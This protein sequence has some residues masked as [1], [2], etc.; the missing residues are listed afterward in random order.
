MKAREVRNKIINGLHEHM[1]IPVYKS[2]QVSPEADL[3]YIV[4]SIITTYTK[5]NTLGHYRVEDDGQGS[6]VEIRGEQAGMSISFTACSQDR[7]C[8]DGERIFGEDEA[9]DLAEKAQGW[10]LLGGRAFLSPEVVVDSVENVVSR[11]TLVVDEE[12]NRYG[13]DVLVKYIREDTRKVDAIRVV[14]SRGEEK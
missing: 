11:S 13:F 4:Y 3:P 14:T 7:K 10:F 2:D 12:A 5:E 8:A 1:Q 6:A 9:M